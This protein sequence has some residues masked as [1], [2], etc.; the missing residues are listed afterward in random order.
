M[1]NKAER[2]ESEGKRLKVTHKEKEKDNAKIRKVHNHGKI[3]IRG[4]RL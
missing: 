1:N 4:Q 2:T 3:Q